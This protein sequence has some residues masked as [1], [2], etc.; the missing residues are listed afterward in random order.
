MRSSSH[1]SASSG[2]TICAAPNCSPTRG[3]AARVDGHHVADAP[4]GQSGD[5]E[6]PD[7]AASDDGHPLP[8][9]HLPLVHRLHADRGRLGQRSDVQA[10]VAWD[11][12][13]PTALGRLPDEE[14]RSEAAF[15][16]AAPQPAQLLVARVDDDPVARR[17]PVHLVAGPL[18][19][20]GH[21]VTQRHR[22]A[23]D[24]AHVHEGDVGAADPARGHPNHGVPWARRP[25]CNVVETNVMGTV[26]PDLL[27]R[28]VPVSTGCLLPSPTAAQYAVPALSC[29]GPTERRSLGT[30]G[31]ASPAAPKVPHPLPD[32]GG[33][34]GRVVHSIGPLAGPQTAGPLWNG[35]GAG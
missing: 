29:V 30:P 6:E 17:D 9:F 23:G 8:W 5:G 10:H 26:D 3:D 2:S 20:A 25:R 15:V 33:E 16:G 27:H 28:P 34:G 1:R 14:E 4:V 13:Q 21:L 32:R 31:C 12:E 19:D 24:A 7:R 18:D 22:P 35:F 11:R